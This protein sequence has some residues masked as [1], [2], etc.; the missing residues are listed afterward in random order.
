MNISFQHS[1]TN[2]R[3]KLRQENALSPFPGLSTKPQ[4][5]WQTA[6]Q[7][8]PASSA[9]QAASPCASSA[10]TAS[11]RPVTPLPQIQTKTPP[12][13]YTPH[14]HKYYNGG[15]PDFARSARLYTQIR[16]HTFALRVP[17]AQRAPRHLARR[18]L[19]TQDPRPQT[20]TQNPTATMKSQ[21]SSPPPH[22][23]GPQPQAPRLQPLP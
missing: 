7:A 6:S 3:C 18:L 15:F 4:T 13:F 10:S 2:I 16:D 1:C 17:R 22:Q 20:R 19:T 8:I 11:L 14:S 21:S 12:H 5:S 23:A 9:M